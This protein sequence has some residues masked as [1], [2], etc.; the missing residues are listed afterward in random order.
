MLLVVKVIPAVLL[1]LVLSSGY[2]AAQNV[3]CYGTVQSAVTDAAGNITVGVVP[4]PPS[5]AQPC[6]SPCNPDPATHW[7]YLSLPAGSPGRDLVYS[8]ALAGVLSGKPV[9]IAAAPSS[10][11]S[12]C[13][14]NV[15]QLKFQ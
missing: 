3:Q 9:Y 6:P 7:T 2:S 14:I 8:G 15:F 11:S 5:T 1:M 12:N 10:G 4:T 13:Q